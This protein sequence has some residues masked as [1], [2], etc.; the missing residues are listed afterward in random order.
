MFSKL[1]KSNTTK[2]VLKIEG[3]HCSGCSNTLSGVLNTVES[4]S[5]S[6]VSLEEHSATI[7]FNPAQKSIEEIINVIESRTP[8]KVTD[9]IIQ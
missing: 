4:I 2:V 1:F 9:K 7:D 8:Y 5:K 6:E 3:M